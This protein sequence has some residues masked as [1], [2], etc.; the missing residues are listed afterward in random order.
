MTETVSDDLTAGKSIADFALTLMREPSPS[1]HES[2]VAELVRQEMLR[3]GYAVEVDAWG[4]VVGTIGPSDGPCVLIDA[5]MDTV[6]VTQPDAW[7]HDPYGAIVGS[8]LYGRGAMDM[9]GPLAAA[10]RGIATLRDSVGSGR[11]VV[12]ASIAEELVEGTA[13]VEIA[14]RERPD[15][16]VICEATSLNVARGQ[17]GRAEIRIETHGRPTHS[18]RP[19]FGVNAAQAMVDVIVALRDVP[20]PRHPVL[21]NGILVLTDVISQ[22]YPGLSVV[23]DRCIATFD[24]RTLPGES[25]DDVLSSV[26]TSVQRALAGSEAT[27]TIQIAEDDFVSY[28]GAQ[29]RAPNFA[30]A[31]FFDED[32]P[33][34][35]LAMQALARA[36]YS[37]RLGHYAFCTNGS[38]TAGRLGIPTIGYGPGD[39]ELAH[40]VDE[41]IEIGDLEASGARLCRH[42]PITSGAWGISMGRPTSAILVRD[43]SSEATIDDPGLALEL[44]ETGRVEN[45]YDY[46]HN[47]VP[48]EGE[49][50]DSMWRYRSLLPLDD[51]PIHYPLSIGGTPLVASPGLRQHLNAPHLWVKDETRTPTGSNK[52]RA[53]ALVLETAMRSGAGVV[54]CAS[55]GNVAVSLAVG[56]AAAGV[57]A[58]IFVPEDVSDSKLTLMLLAGATVFKVREGYDA[59]FRLSRQAAKKFGWH[60]RN[61]GYNPMTLDAKKTVAFEVWEQLGRRV[62]DVVVCPVG[63]GPTLSA[64]AKGFN[65]LQSCGATTRIPRVVGVQAEGCAPLKRAWEHSTPLQPVTPNTIADG[66]AVGNPVSAGMVLR[67]VRRSGGSFVAVS[68]DD[69]RSAMST[70]AARGGLLAEPAGAA[71][72]AGAELCLRE[73]LIDRS[74]RI[75]VLMTGTAM[76]NLGFVRPQRSAVTIS[77]DLSA[78][79]PYVS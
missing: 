62:P 36:G 12:S 41:Y 30:P 45:R 16:V 51:G 19:E 49:Q 29:V 79:E 20:V 34:V 32:E 48:P 64:M 75:V 77:A 60:D 8:R 53:T 31:W 76:K 54:T 17:R 22:P 57:R 37:A 13:L 59:A 71:A 40:R 39:E 35:Q 61:T 52:D 14:R 18:S 42:R 69:L 74:E 66:I 58:V 11:V 50:V 15:Y 55:T 43:D 78:V 5:H 10:I 4:N 27:A 7:S 44:I 73:G 9:K 72:F 26:R 65:E 38:G 23:P 63:D 24:R 6:G 46:G 47:L 25:D 3:L 56:A 33:L 67:D 70:M 21:G 28:S 1:A 2:R 68:D